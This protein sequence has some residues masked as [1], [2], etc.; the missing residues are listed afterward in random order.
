MVLMDLQKQVSTSQYSA[1]I[2]KIK[3]QGT[4]QN[5]KVVI[6]G[7]PNNFI[8]LKIENQFSKQ[9]IESLGKYFPNIESFE[10]RIDEASSL[11]MRNYIESLN[12][13]NQNS[14]NKK[15]LNS[16]KLGINLTN[17]SFSNGIYTSNSSSEKTKQIVSSA[18]TNQSN[19]SD[20]PRSGL[21]P[22]FNFEN[23]VNCEYNELAISVAKYIT[24]NPGEKYNPF[25]IHSSTGLGKTHLLQAIGNYFQSSLPFKTVKYITSENFMNH[26][27]GSMGKGVLSDFKNFYRNLDLILID[28]IQFL[29]SRA[30]TQDQFFH[31][32]NELS[33]NNRNIV[34]A[35]DKPPM[36]LGNFE[37]RLISRFQSGVVI[38]LEPPTIEDRVKILES[39]NLIQKINLKTEQIELIANVV[40]TN[41]RDL[42]GV[43]NKIQ[44]HL[45]FKH[46]AEIS[47]FDLKTALRPYEKTIN[48]GLVQ[49]QTQDYTNSKQYEL[50]IDTLVKQF[51]VEYK[52]IFGNSR[53]PQIVKVRQIA[54]YILYRKHKYSFNSIAKIFN[55]SSHSS[56]AYS[57]KKACKI[58]DTELKARRVVDSII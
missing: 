57:Y 16:E 22:K 25:F 23:L 2:S 54:I 39:K 58:L 1:W 18:E 9:I 26:Y 7:V 12:P 41:I 44:A 21:N 29:A 32:L 35:S 4:A 40:Q 13:N 14:S 49:F 31:I 38:G 8:K 50:D 11:A 45:E 15:S 51:N 47:D 52:S 37:E 34:I 48:V 28:D 55:T 56:M 46:I 3:I 17:L 10:I 27:T 53:N 19:Q 20:K 30:G 24:R 42:E 43:L 33:E 6:L 5:G 36:L